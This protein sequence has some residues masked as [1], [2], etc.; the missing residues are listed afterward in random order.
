MCLIACSAK[1]LQRRKEKLL[2]WYVLTRMYCSLTVRVVVQITLWQSHAL[3]GAGPR[4]QSYPVQ[5]VIN[6]A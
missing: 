6:L 3:L 1:A 4:K 5:S 2:K